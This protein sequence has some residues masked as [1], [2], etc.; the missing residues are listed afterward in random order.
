MKHEVRSPPRPPRD[1]DTRRSPRRPCA[2]RHAERAALRLV[3]VL[4]R[5]SADTPVQ[6][7]GSR[8]PHSSVAANSR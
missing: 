7:S 6:L 8:A 3:N 5:G 1:P 2:T 4:V